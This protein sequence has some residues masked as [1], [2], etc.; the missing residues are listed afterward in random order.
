ME[1]PIITIKVIISF[2]CSYMLLSHLHLTTLNPTAFA[3][4]DCQFPAVFNFGDSNSDTGGLASSLIA[5]TPPYGETFFGMPAGRFSDG[6]LTIDFLAKSVGHPFLSAYLD[7]LGTNFSSGANFATAASTIRLPN[8][9]IPSGGF[10]P[11]FLDIQYMQFMQ[12]KSRSRLI[13]QRES[14][15]LYVHNCM[16]HYW[17]HAKRLQKKEHGPSR[18]LEKLTKLFPTLIEDMY[19][20]L[21]QALYAD[22]VRH[23]RFMSREIVRGVIAA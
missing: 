2:F 22:K 19:A 20:G 6:R 16:K 1:S 11:F 5:P 7:S 21:A 8:S 15:L 9:V 12:F 13:R 3:L 10:S 14:W 23:P 4:E 18:V 17:E